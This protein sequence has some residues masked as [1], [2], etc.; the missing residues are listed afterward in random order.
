M[1]R[2]GVC[3]LLSPPAMSLL[4]MDAGTLS[5]FIQAACPDRTKG[6]GAPGA[7][8]F[9][10]GRPSPWRKRSNRQGLQPWHPCLT[11]PPLEAQPLVGSLMWVLVSKV[12]TQHI[13]KSWTWRRLGMPKPGQG[14]RPWLED[15]R[16]KDH[17]CPQP[18]WQ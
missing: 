16:R 7:A 15:E 4:P 2:E 11:I 14:I 5:P 3:L 6:Q 9:R 10:K 8:P 13:P 12:N 18:S 17:P 1:R